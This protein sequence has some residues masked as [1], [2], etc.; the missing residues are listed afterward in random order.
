MEIFSR[1]LIAIVFISFAA[2][3][4]LS[5]SDD[6]DKSTTPPPPPPVLAAV[7]TNPVAPLANGSALV[8]GNVT[9]TGGAAVT[10]RGVTWSFVAN[11]NMN[12]NVVELGMGT[13]AFSTT[14][15][16]L[17]S[18]TTYHIRAFA[19]NSVG[20]AYGESRAFTTLGEIG[21]ISTPGA[22]VTDIE[23]KFYPS[24]IINNKE[25][26]TINLAVK[27]FNNGEDIPN[28][29]Q[30]NDWN[31]LSTPARCTYLNDNDLGIIY[32]NL[33]NWHAVV[34]ERS[35]CPTGWRMPTESDFSELIALLGGEVQAGGNIKETGIALWQAPNTGAS[36]SSGLSGKPSG[37]RSNFGGFNEIGVQMVWWS[38]AAAPTG[39]FALFT[40]NTSTAAEQAPVPVT[41]GLAVRCVKE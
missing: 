11:P 36:N 27:K 22:G 30:N 34:D 18:S 3:V 1:R 25:W 28:V 39:A 5:C 26:M 12:D 9:A 19:E 33:Y 10:R 15:T 17:S 35:L 41:H 6:D 16:E 14:L 4:F 20:I 24:V 7:N 37:R 29:A 40:N 32:G 8:G 38:A 21:G 23:G 2:G 13:G 31:V